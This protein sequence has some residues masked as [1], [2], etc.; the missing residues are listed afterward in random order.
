MKTTIVPVYTPTEDTDDGRKGAFYDQL[1]DT[2]EDIPS[3]DLKILVGN[4]NAQIDNK[5]QGVEY[6]IGPFG[7]A[8]KANDNGERLTL[9]QHQ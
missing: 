9:L 7:S 2:F 3:H 5:K 1:Q 6:V 8:Q 4:L